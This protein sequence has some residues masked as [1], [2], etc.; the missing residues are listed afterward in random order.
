MPR[1][2]YKLSLAIETNKLHL[3][4]IIKLLNYHNSHLWQKTSLP[5]PLKMDPTKTLPKLPITPALMSFPISN[6]S[7]K[8]PTF[9]SI[10][11]CSNKPTFLSS[12]K[13]CK[14]ISYY[15]ILH[16][17]SSSTVFSSEPSTK[18]TTPLSTPQPTPTHTPTMTLINRRLCYNYEEL[19][20]DIVTTV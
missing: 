18:S 7:S 4:R 5:Q 2:T 3:K 13:W 17:S 14:K 6:K 20:V 11:S 19:H 12:F 15:P 16:L 10:D 9:Y 8:D 1:I